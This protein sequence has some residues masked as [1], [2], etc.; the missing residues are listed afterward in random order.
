MLGLGFG[1][2]F[3]LGIRLGLGFRLGLGIRCEFGLGVDR[4]W[5]RV[6]VKLLV[7]DQVWLDRVRVQI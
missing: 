1:F 4:V 3:E 2:Q 7:W 6:R 5:V